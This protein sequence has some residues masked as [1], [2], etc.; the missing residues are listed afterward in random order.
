MMGCR[1]FV[2]VA[3]PSGIGSQDDAFEVEGV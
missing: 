1:R 3:H 2:P